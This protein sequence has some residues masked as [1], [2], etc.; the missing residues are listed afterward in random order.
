MRLQRSSGEP[1]DRCTPRATPLSPALFA[2]FRRAGPGQHPHVR[3]MI[4]SPRERRRTATAAWIFVS[5]PAANIDRRRVAAP[6]VVI[7]L[8]N[9]LALTKAADPVVIQCGL[10]DL[11]DSRRVATFLRGVANLIEETGK[12]S[13]DRGWQQARSSIARTNSVHVALREGLRR[14]GVIQ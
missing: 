12:V 5:R 1:F 11:A 2:H 4:P 9:H 13:F 6:E 8:C 10:T 3:V 7:L 14:V